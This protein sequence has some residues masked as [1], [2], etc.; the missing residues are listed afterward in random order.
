MDKKNV[1]VLSIWIF[2]FGLLVITKSSQMV[3]ALLFTLFVLTF[4]EN[5]I[6]KFS[7][8]KKI[9]KYISTFTSIIILTLVII[10]LYFSISFMSK[11][12]LVLIKDSQ[13]HLIANLNFIG[14]NNINDLSEKLIDYI[15]SNLQILSNGLIVVLKILIGI[16]FG[17]VFY[18][19]SL[20]FK[21]EG[22]LESAIIN[23]LRKYG[24]KIFIAFKNI[25]EVQIIVATLNT[26][27]I[28]ILALG[29]YLYG[30][31]LPFWYIIIPIT[32]ILS[33]IPVIGNIMINV[34]LLL[35]TIQ[36]SL[37]AAIVG[38][39]IFLFAHKLELIVIGKKIKE[40]IDVSFI[41]VLI[42]MLIG[43]LL[44]NSMAGM[45]LGMVIM[46]SLCLITREIK[47]IK[48]DK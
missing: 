14:I 3:L 23:D 4:S 10:G 22:T 37:I 33:L 42:S 1:I 34:V 27:I 9:N 17:F 46:L 45:L 28:S 24:Q 2:L 44:F 39:S 29:F 15:N 47:Y 32:F 16:I 48:E 5:F 35:S 26:L 6:K 11:D 7:K 21:A 13:T 25:I 12:L 31:I 19:S 41:L 30:E 8:N 18:F 38:I 40:K 20:R 36:I 43:E